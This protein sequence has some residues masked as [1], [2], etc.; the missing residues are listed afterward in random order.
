MLGFARGDGLNQYRLM[1]VE[2]PQALQVGFG[3]QLRE[4]RGGRRRGVRRRISLV[5]AVGGQAEHV[6]GG[7]GVSLEFRITADSVTERD[8][9]RG[10]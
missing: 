8:G 4:D 10:P 5:W 3:C 6:D 2:V 7:F 9:L 1:S